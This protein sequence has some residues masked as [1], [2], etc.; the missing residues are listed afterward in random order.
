VVAAA[1]A[2]GGVFAGRARFRLGNWTDGLDGRFDAIVAN[3]PYIPAREIA[4]LA[5]EVARH[6]PRAAL[7]GGRDGLDAYRKLLPGL[8]GLLAPGGIAVLE[9]G[10]GQADAVSALAASNGLRP[11]GH[12]RDLAGIDRAVLI[13]G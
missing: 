12:S 5:P 8:R 7:D 10:A 1:K 9:V 4:G 6:E 3:P 2:R 13:T 11:T